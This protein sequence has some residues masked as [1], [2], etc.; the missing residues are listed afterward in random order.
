MSEGMHRFKDE[1]LSVLATWNLIEQFSPEPIPEP[2]E[3][4]RRSRHN[5]RRRQG[6]DWR[7]QFELPSPALDE[8]PDDAAEDVDLPVRFHHY[9]R[10]E[11]HRG[12]G[13]NGGQ[14]PLP[15]YQV[16]D[17]RPGMVFPWQEIADVDV[18][19]G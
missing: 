8:T 13:R 11:V 4:K 19:E 18:L 16:L 9:Q 6:E 1:Q 15:D 7:A 12:K 10:A 3:R 17:L 2:T 5:G 14:A